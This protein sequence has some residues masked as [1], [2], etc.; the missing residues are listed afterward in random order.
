MVDSIL[1]YCSEMRDNQNLTDVDN[2]QLRYLI[3]FGALN[4]KLQMLAYMENLV[5]IRCHWLQKKILDQNNEKLEH[6]CNF[7][8]TIYS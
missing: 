6:Y 2:I 8:D 7:K 1:L 4:N 3:A 5:D